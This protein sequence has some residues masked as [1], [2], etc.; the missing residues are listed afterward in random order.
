MAGR[1]RKTRTGVA[2]G[3]DVP[4]RVTLPSGRTLAGEVTL[5]PAEDGRRRYESWGE[6][7]MWVSGELL[8][9]LSAAYR[10]DDRARQ[11][12]LL[13]LESEASHAAGGTTALEA[14]VLRSV[15][16]QRAR[17]AR[18]PAIHAR[19]AGPPDGHPHSSAISSG[20]GSAGGFHASG[21]VTP[22]MT[23]RRARS[24]STPTQKAA[25]PRGKPA[26]TAMSWGDGKT[27]GVI[28]PASPR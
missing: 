3:V 25:A 26:A 14:H 1:P 22:V 9:A 8:A 18:T 28:T 27:A 20:F 10:G 21:S 12:A 23:P 24:I 2:H 15:A 4:V 7:D 17:S 13:V 11:D 6:P 19:E 5:C 16:T